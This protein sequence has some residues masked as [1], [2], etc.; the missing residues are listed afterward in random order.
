MK[1]EHIDCGHLEK[2]WLPYAVREQ[3]YGM[4]SHPFCLKCGIVKNIGPDRATGRGYFINVISR[5]EKHLK[6]PG[7]SVR[8]R[9][10]AK[11]LEKVEDF[12]DKYSM[13][14]YSQEKIFINLVKKYYRIPE[15]TIMQFL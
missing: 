1:C 12:D 4:K 13:S 5:I 10:I 14:K 15:R 8:M 7:S 9:L 2:V 3:A 6:I 11:D